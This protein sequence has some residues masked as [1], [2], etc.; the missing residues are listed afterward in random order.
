MTYTYS[1]ISEPTENAGISRLRPTLIWINSDESCCAF[2]HF[3][4]ATPMPL[5]VRGVILK[6]V[7]LIGF[8]GVLY[9]STI[10]TGEAWDDDFAMYFHEAKNIAVGIDYR[11]TGY[12]YERESPIRRAQR[13]FQG[14][15]EEVFGG[16]A[17]G[18]LEPQ[19]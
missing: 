13:F 5:E 10:R 7:L 3:S 6:I 11:N 17:E 12:I 9:L 19:V 18:L 1:R 8:V 4:G 14:F 2:G 16:F 15:C